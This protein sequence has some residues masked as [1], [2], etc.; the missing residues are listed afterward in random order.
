[1]SLFHSL[2]INMRHNSTI[3]IHTPKHVIDHNSSLQIDDG[4]L[5]QILKMNTKTEKKNQ[6]KGAKQNTIRNPVA[7]IDQCA[8]ERKKRIHLRCIHRR[9]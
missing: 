4:N 9:A 2:T 8:N 3:Q 7:R 5:M 6:Y 1:M